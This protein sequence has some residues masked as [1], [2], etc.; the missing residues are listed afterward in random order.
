MLCPI[1]N[2]IM[3]MKTILVLSLAPFALALPQGSLPVV[4]EVLGGLS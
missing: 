1:V 2:S 3:L 4:G